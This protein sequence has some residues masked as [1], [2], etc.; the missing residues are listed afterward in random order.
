V[1]KEIYNIYSNEYFWDLKYVKDFKQREFT[2]SWKNL[3]LRSYLLNLDFRK[4]ISITPINNIN[5][6]DEFW[7]DKFTKDFLTLNKTTTLKELELN[8]WEQLYEHALSVSNNYPLQPYSCDENDINK[9][10]LGTVP[11]LSSSDAK[12]YIEEI[13]KNM[14]DNWGFEI[15]KSNGKRVCLYNIYVSSKDKSYDQVGYEENMKMLFII[16]P[17]SLINNLDIGDCLILYIFECG[18]WSV[19]LTRDINTYTLSFRKSY[20]EEIFTINERYAI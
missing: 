8:S 12:F 9:I 16:E 7:Y 13:V 4:L 20:K 17:S 19:I 15:V 10:Y 2:H 3:Y 18:P 6:D 5:L 1:N 14:S 11:L